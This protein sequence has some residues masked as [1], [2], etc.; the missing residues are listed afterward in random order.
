MLKLALVAVVFMLAFR[1]DADTPKEPETK[2]VC[3]TEKD[4]KGN[5]KETC[6]TIQI[7]KKLEPQKPAQK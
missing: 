2:R 7:H 5:P 1:A 3:V 6:K 4:S